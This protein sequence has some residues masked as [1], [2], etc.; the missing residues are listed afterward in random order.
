LLRRP[1][2]QWDASQDA[3]SFEIYLTDGTTDIYV[4]DLASTSWQPA[5][6]LDMAVW[7][8]QVRGSNSEM[9]FGQ[10]STPISTDLYGRA[11]VLTTQPDIQNNTPAISW[12]PV[13]GS[14]R[15][16]LRVDNE[17]TGQT[18]VVYRDDL[19]A[20]NYQLPTMSDG[21]YRLWVRAVSPS[22]SLAPWS[23]TFAFTIGES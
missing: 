12:T 4:Q 10:W 19:Q 9:Q 7:S 20:P 3:E 17:S 23:Q 15:Y 14:A 18:F 13:T 6:D 2:F 8:W 5:E 22:G 1:V 11:V 21:S 16:V